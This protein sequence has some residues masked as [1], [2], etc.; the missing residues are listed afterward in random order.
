LLT[1]W[2]RD[3]AAAPAGAGGRGVKS[4]RVLFASAQA[5][6]AMV[7]AVGAAMLVQSYA[8]LMRQDI[9][10]DGTALVAD[11][12][13]PRT[14]GGAAL[15][16]TVQASI[17]ALR[18]LPGVQAVAASTG[19]LPAGAR[20]FL[21]TVKGERVPT[22]GTSVSPGFFDA[23]GMALVE[24][25]ALA[26][27]DSNWSGIVVNQAFARVHWPA[28]SPL[29]QVVNYQATPRQAHVVGVVRN[30]LGQ[31]PTEPR[32]MVYELMNAESEERR[33]G[34]AVISYVIRSDADPR[35]HHEA[36]RRAIAGS[37][38]D[39]VI[40]A[41]D[42]IDI[43]LANTVRDRTFATLVLTFFGIAG[44]A[45]TITGLIGIVTFVVARRTREIAIRMAIGA[46]RGHV[47]RLVVREAV[48]AAVAGGLAGLLAGRWLS[49][50]LESLVYGIEA[51]NWTTTLAAGGVMLALMVFAA[52]VPARRAVNLQPTEALRV[53]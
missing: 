36:I 26:A 7:L 48:T 30:A 38:R 29:G 15:A 45:V 51:G 20:M 39:G 47:R 17:D 11:V 28:A 9:G 3:A 49:G 40:G 35:G 4:L 31:L 21:V 52:L 14:L 2:R 32:P 13:Y 53:E 16:G 43:R 1:T 18:R 34:D 6:L 12:T 37:N 5:A 41:I 10:Y 44:G 33:L 46:D 42:T 24:G 25:R 23:A 27:G 19:R 22:S 50:W 8:N